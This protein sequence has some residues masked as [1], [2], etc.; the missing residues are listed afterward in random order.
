MGFN[1]LIRELN[2]LNTEISKY[3]V[4]QAKQRL[5]NTDNSTISIMRMH[6]LEFETTEYTQTTIRILCER[7]NDLFIDIIQPIDQNILIQHYLRP[8]D[9]NTVY[10]Y[11]FFEISHV[12]TQPILIQAQITYFYLIIGIGVENKCE[13]K[14]IA[15]NHQDSALI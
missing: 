4:V 14:L 6:Q 10:P 7:I 2:A 9:E 12:K 3:A 15:C 13:N 1:N 11:R 8:Q 5:I